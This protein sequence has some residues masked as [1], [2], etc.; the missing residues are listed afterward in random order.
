MFAKAIVAEF[1]NII[2]FHESRRLHYKAD[3]AVHVRDH[4]TRHE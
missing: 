2:G 1:D 3:T 4:V